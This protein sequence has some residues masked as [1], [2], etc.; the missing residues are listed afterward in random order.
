[1]YNFKHSEGPENGHKL[2]QIMHQLDDYFKAHYD[3]HFNVITESVEIRKRGGFN[4][5]FIPLRE[6]QLNG[7]AIEAMV[8]TSSDSGCAVSR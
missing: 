1:M 5:D 7:L 2:K 8:F 3:Y 4:L 6:R